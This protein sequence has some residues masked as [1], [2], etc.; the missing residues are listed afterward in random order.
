MP[1]TFAVLRVIVPDDVPVDVVADALW[2]HGPASVLEGERALEAGFA[3]EEAAER[4][5]AALPWPSTVESV[6]D[7]S[8]QD[9][10]RAHAGV[11][12][13]GGI[14]VVP[15]WRH[16]VVID[17]GSAFGSGS[18]PSTRLCLRALSTLVGSETSVLDVGCGSGVLAIAAARLGASRVVA[19][20]VA[21]EAVEATRQN[22]TGNGVE[23]DA[24]HAI[25][26][27]I[28]DTFEVV[29][30]NIGSAVLRSMARPLAQRVDGAL[31]LAGL[32]D[33]QVPETVA[34]FSGTGLAL[35][36]CDSLDGWSA[37]VLERR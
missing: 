36:S 37:P 7:D 5:A 28:A 17:P 26:D 16:V 14:V 10:W 25:V 6:L 15:A 4:V 12:E 1:P 13:E 27:D 23:I 35:T 22:A 19:I 33:E 8:W 21:S 18:H 34:A 29:V 30:A 20:D 24:R 32:L 3:S 2:Q 9:A 11:I 31:V